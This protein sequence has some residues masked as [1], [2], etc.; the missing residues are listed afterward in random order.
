MVKPLFF[1]LKMLSASYVN[2]IHSRALQT[3]FLMEENNI[4]PAWEQSD[5]GPYWFQY[6]LPKNIRELQTT[7][8]ETHRPR[9]N[10]KINLKIW[11]ADVF[12]CMFLRKQQIKD[13]FFQ[14]AVKNL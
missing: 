12:C 11:L 7:T 3:R 14:V 1:V 8:V 4:N 9:D 5:L 10:L 13:D 2:C 6:R